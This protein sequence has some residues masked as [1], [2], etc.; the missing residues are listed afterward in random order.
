MQEKLWNSKWLFCYLFKIFVSSV[1]TSSEQPIDRL[2]NFLLIRTHS[3]CFGDEK[4]EDVVLCSI[5][6]CLQGGV[7]C[8]A[9]PRQ[10]INLCTDAFYRSSNI[11]EY[12]RVYKQ[13]ILNKAVTRI[14]KT[15]KYLTQLTWQKNLD[16]YCEILK[17][18]YIFKGLPFNSQTAHV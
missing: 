17:L 5:I 12:L 7:Q 1:I 10:P 15:R 3:A 18:I 16:N 2:H 14:R 8:R 11:Y 4:L 6:L 13:V 9:L